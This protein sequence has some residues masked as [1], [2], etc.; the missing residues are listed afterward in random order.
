MERIDY[1]IIVSA[2]TI[3]DA[4]PNREFIGFE[5]DYYVIHSLVK[6]WKP[7]SIFE[8]GTNTGFGCQVLKRASPESTIKTL[9]ILPD[10]G[11]LCPD[12]VEKIVGDSLTYDY[13]YNYP[14]DCWFIDGAHDYEHVY[15]ETTE[16]LKSG[17]NYIIYHDADLKPVADGLLQ[18]FK[19]SGEY[20]SYELFFVVNPPF[21]YS[22][23]GENVTRVAYAVKKIKR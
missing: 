13:T 4:L 14:I 11:N 22:S 15:C 21:T 17:P 8:I 23:T 18:A 6:S 3:A 16:A 19:D 20:S 1:N 10:M 7:K 12:D 2:E 9:D 5:Q